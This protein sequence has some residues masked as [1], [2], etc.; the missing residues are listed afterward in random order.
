MSP[1]RDHLT[2]PTSDNRG[3]TPSIEI[4]GSQDEKHSTRKGTTII[5]E[6]AQTIRIA[7]SRNPPPFHIFDIWPF[8]LCIRSIQK[9]GRKLKG[10]R[11]LRDRAMNKDA[12]DGV[13]NV[14]LEITLYLSRYIA[15]L[16]QRGLD[17]LTGGQMMGAL[18]QLVDALTGLERILSTPVP[19]AVSFFSSSLITT[20]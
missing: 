19:W 7:P 5:D 16:Q 17:G 20:Y 10:K 2:V 8:Y 1:P 4:T 9:R 11:A 13:E 3:R 14:P 6:E 15:S 18:S 12:K